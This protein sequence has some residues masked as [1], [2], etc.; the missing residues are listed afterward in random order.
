MVDKLKEIPKKLLE[1]WNKFSPKQKTIIV[2]AVAGVIV[3]FAVLATVLT[4]PVYETL[5]IT[6]TTKETATITSLLEGDGIT[7]Q[8]SDDGFQIKVLKQEIGGAHV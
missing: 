6:E 5:V 3:A 2:S 4:K 7:Y 8:V 1:W